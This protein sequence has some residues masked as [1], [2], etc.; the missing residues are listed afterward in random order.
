MRTG[1]AAAA[2]NHE[3]PGTVPRE[4]GLRLVVAERDLARR[5]LSYRALGQGASAVVAQDGWVVCATNP[6]ARTHLEAGTVIRLMVAPAC[7]AGT[8]AR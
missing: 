4:T 8:P 6:S 7:H 3:G 2:A 5:K 1:S